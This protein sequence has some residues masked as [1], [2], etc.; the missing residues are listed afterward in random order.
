MD[1]VV[2]S[3]SMTVFQYITSLTVSQYIALHLIEK[4]C[5]ILASTEP[6]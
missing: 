2:C 6:D 5:E 4:Y 1:M 3:V